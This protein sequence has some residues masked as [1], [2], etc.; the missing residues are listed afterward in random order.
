MVE[1]LNQAVR[2]SLSDEDAATYVQDRLSNTTYI[3]A[4][5]KQAQAYRKGQ[6][7]VVRKISDTHLTPIRGYSHRT[8]SACFS[9]SVAFRHP[10]ISHLSNHLL[11]LLDSYIADRDLG[12]RS[13]QIWLDPAA[14]LLATDDNHGKAPVAE[15]LGAQNGPSRCDLR[16]YQIVVVLHERPLNIVYSNSFQCVPHGPVSIHLNTKCQFSA[17]LTLYNAGHCDFDSS[18]ASAGWGRTGLK[19]ASRSPL[20][21]TTNMTG[22]RPFGQS[23]V[24]GFEQIAMFQVKHLPTESHLGSCLKPSR[25]AIP[26]GYRF[27]FVWISTNLP[28]LSQSPFLG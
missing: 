7:E 10:G 15:R 24:S 4:S 14:R 28:G 18:L 20:L 27:L 25:N 6:V 2:A 26:S 11:F 1:T 21:Q 5:P 16:R 23:S 8:A 19:F 12:S 9:V 17:R 3:I 22:S 13:R